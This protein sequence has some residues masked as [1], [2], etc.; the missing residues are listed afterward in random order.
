VWFARSS[1][2]HDHIKGVIEARKNVIEQYPEEVESLLNGDNSDWEHGFNNGMLAGMRYVLG[3][4]ENGKEDA[5][6][7]FPFLDT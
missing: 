4:A 7:N 3:M 5:V 6:E 2:K 1:P